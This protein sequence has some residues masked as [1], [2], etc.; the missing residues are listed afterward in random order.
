MKGK[1]M[2]A[3]AVLVTGIAFVGC[4]DDKKEETAA[5][6]EQTATTP[7]AEAPVSGDTSETSLDWAGTY[8]GNLPGANS[9]METTVVLNADKTFAMTTVYVDKA[10]EKFE[11]KGTFTWNA[12]GTIVTLKNEKGDATQFK[13]QEGSILKLDQ[14]GKEITGPTANL[15]ELKKK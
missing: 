1:K 15:Y 7:E 10:N 3:L 4:K 5:P 8:V 12:E 6:T 13:V 14:D 11:E 9:D 2:L